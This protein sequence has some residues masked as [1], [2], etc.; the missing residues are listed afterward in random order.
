MTYADPKLVILGLTQAEEAAQ[1]LRVRVVV[2]DE[3][4]YHSQPV[5][6]TAEALAALAPQYV[7]KPVLDRQHEISESPGEV[8]GI[9]EASEAVGTKMVQVHRYWAPH[10]IREIREG[11]QQGYSVSY[12]RTA[13]TQV[14]RRNK[15]EL[16]TAAQ[17]LEVTRTYAP[18]VSGTGVTETLRRKGA[19]QMADT[20]VNEDGTPEAKT[21]EAE[22]MADMPVEGSF[23]GT[24]SG[25]L[26]AP[27]AEG[28]AAAADGEPQAQAM[29]MGEAMALRQQV[30]AL[31]AET[32][33]LR[34]ERERET[35]TVALRQW[36]NEG[37][38]N[39]AIP[40]LLQATEGIP[41]TA[42]RALMA[43][44]PAAEPRLAGV[45][46]ANGGL[47][48][49]Q[50]DDPAEAPLETPDQLHRGAMQ[51]SNRNKISYA[52]AMVQLRAARDARVRR[53]QQ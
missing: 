21:V 42:L 38:L 14:V 51:L 44:I 6:L 20:K 4:T 53:V 16:W 48:A 24:I 7:G 37:R 9:I 10:V 25:T 8:I 29:S 28:D 2:Y 11:V 19:R 27:P 26:A 43:F 40:A 33:Q 36:R 50:G 45:Q 39:G 35:R 18:V 31:R 52:E 13:A 5:G 3:A 15:R 47:N 12:G 30:A 49:D 46:L 1:Q 22:Q 23:T 17:A 41:V 34:Q 32:Q